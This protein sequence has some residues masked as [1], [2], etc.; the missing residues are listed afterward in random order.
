[1]P[2]P[3][4]PARDGQPPHKHDRGDHDDSPGEEPNCSTVVLVRRH[5]VVPPIGVQAPEPIT[6]PEADRQVGPVTSAST[7]PTTE[8]PSTTPQRPP[9]RRGDQTPDSHLF[10]TRPYDLVKEFTLALVGVLSS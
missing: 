9:R 2:G 10:P 5:G 3:G 7:P 8:Q 4:R 1:M 6:E